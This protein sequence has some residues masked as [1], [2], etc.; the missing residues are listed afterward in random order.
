MKR[1]MKHWKQK[2]I[3]LAYVLLGK[4]ELMKNTNALIREYFPQGANFKNIS[5]TDI[6]YIETRLNTRL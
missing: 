2:L 5:K 4:N 6:C 1:S 3:L